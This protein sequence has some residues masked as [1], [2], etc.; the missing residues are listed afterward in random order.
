MT[1]E[2]AIEKARK[3]LNLA[4]SDNPNEAASAAAQ[5]QKILDKYEITKT[6]LE[7]HGEEEPDNEDV[8]IFNKAPLHEATR[9]NL[10]K[11]RSRLAQIIANNNMC[12]IFLRTA[13][14]NKQVIIVGRPSDVEKVRYLFDWMFTET[15]RLCSRDGVGMGRTWR[16][17]YRHGIVDTISKKMIEA[18]QEVVAE[19]KAVNSSSTALVRVESAL[20]KI[21]KRTEQSKSKVKEVTGGKS[22]YGSRM[23]WQGEAR[24]QGRKA[25][26]EI[27]VNTKARGALKS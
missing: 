17:N 23:T 9:F 12:D 8:A 5:A 4:N 13:G 10:D 7:E 2:E 19:L 22:D 16:N 15:E 1:L 6:M 20:Q 26:E 27:N 24:L 14:N 25:G 18:R 21:E 11:W 3:L